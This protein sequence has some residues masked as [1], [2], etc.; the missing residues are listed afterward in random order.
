MPGHVLRHFW[1][2]LFLHTQRELNVRLNFG[3]TITKAR[4]YICQ[5]PGQSLQATTHRTRVCPG[6]GR[7]TTP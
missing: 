2:P 3:T 4:E 7:N 1:V 5:W 6:A